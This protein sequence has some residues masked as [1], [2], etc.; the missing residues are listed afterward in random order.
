MHAPVFSAHP[1]FVGMETFTGISAWRNASAVTVNLP[2]INIEIH[3][4]DYLRNTSMNESTGGNALRFQQN[5][6]RL[7]YQVEGHGILHNATKNSFGTAKPGLIGVMEAGERHSYMHQKGAFECF[8]MEFALLPSKQA[9]CYWNSEI[10]GRRFLE[11]DERLYFENLI[12]DLIRVIANDREILG[13]ASISRILEVIVVLFSKGLLTI[14]ESQFPQN[15]TRSLVDK[16]RQ[17]MK[18]H[19]MD[20]RHQ[21]ELSEHCGVDINYLNVLFEKETGKTLYKYLT[22]IRMEYAKYLL[23]EKKLPV[24]DIAAQVGYPSGNSFTRAFRKYLNRTPTAYR[25]QNSEI[26]KK[27]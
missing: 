24:I 7:W 23:E 4:I 3:S 22:D 10:E 8:M 18:S 6:Y 13:L 16:A 15:K 17:Y 11:Q 26:H 2:R 20:M 9:K 14:S 5:H 25:V 12:F 21:R 27:Q 19:Y 1:D